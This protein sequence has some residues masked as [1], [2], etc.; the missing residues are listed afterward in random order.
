MYNVVITGHGIV[1]IFFKVKPSLIGG[2]GNI[3]YYKIK[4]SLKNSL[5]NQYK[6]FFKVNSDNQNINDLNINHQL[7]PYLAGLIEGD[8]SFIVPDPELKKRHPLIRICF[9]SKDLPFAQI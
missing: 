9:A 3:K 5:K 8:G 4:V 6:R 1:K 7:G 2:F